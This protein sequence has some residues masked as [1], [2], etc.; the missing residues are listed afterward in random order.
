MRTPNSRPNGFYQL[1]MD[2]MPGIRVSKSLIAM[3]KCGQRNN[4]AVLMAI[5]Q[6]DH[7]LSNGGN[8]N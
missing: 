6:A 8:K 7:I 3:V 4:D 1:V 5:I 2:Q